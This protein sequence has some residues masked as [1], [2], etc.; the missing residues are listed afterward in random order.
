LTATHAGSV[1]DA[2]LF[3]GH[4]LTESV[5]EMAL[6]L[7][8]IDTIRA[9]LVNLSPAADRL[10]IRYVVL[11]NEARVIRQATF[12]LSSPTPCWST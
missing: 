8:R 3:P 1:S 9:A 5:L 12:I 2:N 11:W 10:T 7:A 6:A 4:I